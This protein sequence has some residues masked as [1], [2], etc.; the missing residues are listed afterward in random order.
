VIDDED[1][2]QEFAGAFE[3]HLTVPLPSRP[4][5][6]DEALHQWANRH[7]I[8][9]TRIRLDRGSTPDQPMLTYRGQG[10]LTMQRSRAQGWVTRL[11]DAG[12]TIGIR[13]R[14]SRRGVRGA[15]RQPGRGRRLG[16]R[17]GQRRM[18]G[19]HQEARWRAA[20]RA[21]LDHVLSLIAETPWSENLVLRGSMVM[22]AWAGHRAR[23]PA[24]LDFV[25]LPELN[26]PVDP[27]EPY[28][29]VDR[30][31][32]VQQWP[33][34]ADGA[35]RYE[36]WMDGEEQYETRGLHPRTA[37][38]GLNWETDREAP[39]RIPPPYD[40]PHRVRRQPQATPHVVLDA[41]N[42]REDHTWGYAYSAHDTA[43]VRILIPWQAEGLPRGE[44]QIDFALDERLP[45]PPVWTPI[46]RGDGGAPSIIRTASRELS[47]AWKLQWLYTDAAAGHGQRCKDL[48]DAVLL[49]QDDRTRLSPRLLRKVLRDPTSGAAPDGLSLDSVQFDEKDWTAFRAEH[50]GAQGTAQG[51]LHRLAAALA[52]I[53]ATLHA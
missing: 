27:L 52:P 3:T 2:V 18:I 40:L 15:R 7:G 6:S 26:T 35:A 5:D 21:A 47:L 23:E 48:Y 36:I 53:S 42:A 24:D 45:R 34:A 33:E 12:F 22:T 44:V 50:P 32:V 37:P 41:D 10:I 29:H 30:V 25:V 51:W 31:D 43:G 13:G 17:T 8:K 14:G 16:R 39:D 28:P 19:D 20:R 46:P 4:D 49:A 1:A 9:Y 11:R 38:D